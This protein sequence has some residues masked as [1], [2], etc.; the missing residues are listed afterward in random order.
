MDDQL[1]S[2]IKNKIRI[3]ILL[4]SYE[5]FVNERRCIIVC[6]EMMSIIQIAKININPRRTFDIYIIVLQEAVKLF[7]HA[8]ASSGALTEVIQ[9]CI[10]GIGG[11]CKT[12]NEYNKDYYFDSI[13]R[14][15]QIRAFHDWPD[16][17]Y[18]LLRTAVCLVC[19]QK[20]ANRIYDIFYIFGKMFDGKDYA[21]KHVIIHGII[22]R[23]EGKK[24]ADKYL[25]ENIHIDEMRTIAVES[26]IEEKEY[27]AAEKLC[28][29]ALQKSRRKYLNK[30]TIWAYYL[31]RIY[32]E[33]DNKDK[34]I[35][36]F[37][38]ILFHGDMSYIKKLKELYQK[39]DEYI[40]NE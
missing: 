31:E 2:D 3:A 15:V 34:L 33:T 39:E 20:Q 22:E 40:T 16:Y 5:G 17:G 24:A 8:D 1:I 13:I 21:D 32:S 4:N 30:P 29:E 6:T 36:M 25:I 37:F 10:N 7:F 38:H 27:E 23:I 9:A 35:E 18:K 19:N 26:L 28:I 14:S 11:L 12:A